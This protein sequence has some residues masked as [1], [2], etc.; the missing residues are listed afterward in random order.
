MSGVESA[1]VAA[2]RAVV[3]GTVRAWLGERKHRRERSS[4]LVEL[5]APAVPDLLARRRVGRQF[6]EIADEVA[7]RLDRAFG[8]DRLPENEKLSAL[9][10]VVDTLTAADLSD[11]ALFAA[12]A[13]PAVLAHRLRQ[14]SAARVRAAGLGEAGTAFYHRVL[15]DC[16][17][18]LVAM[19]RQLPAFEP[20]AM[21][22]TL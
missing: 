2:G 3:T 1:L 10:E 20:R 21:A 16:A 8:P 12:D 15:D 6:E 22:E 5:L 14:G 18:V 9:A 17:G 13:D 19:V 11:S 7:A 4:D